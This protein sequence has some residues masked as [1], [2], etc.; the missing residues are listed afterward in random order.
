MQ[1][2]LIYVSGCTTPVRLFRGERAIRMYVQFGHLTKISFVL[3]VFTWYFIQSWLKLYKMYHLW[4][5][6]YMAIKNTEN[7]LN[8]SI[9]ANSLW[10]LIMYVPQKVL[11]LLVS[12]G[13]NYFKNEGIN[14]SIS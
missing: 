5:E 6:I 14:N 8:I 10:F 11:Y 9:F 13:N 2:S 7:V 4:K 1:V 3:N 12:L